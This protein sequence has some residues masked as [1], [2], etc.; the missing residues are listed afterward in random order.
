M[1]ERRPRLILAYVVVGLG[2]MALM[3]AITH[4]K[5]ALIFGAMF[6]Y[7]AAMVHGLTF[8]LRA[9][10]RAE[11]AVLLGASRWILGATLV[12][13]AGTALANFILVA[14]YVGSDRA[15]TSADAT[16]ALAWAV[17]VMV[18]CYRVWV[19][20]SARRAGF[21][22]VIAVAFAVPGMLVTIAR[23]TRPFYDG[24]RGLVHHVPHDARIVLGTAMFVTFIV[25]AA[26]GPVLDK[27]F[28]SIDDREVN[29][30]PAAVL[31]A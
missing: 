6:G 4:H 31:R 27:L 15:S 5:S 12:A 14:V 8:A 10:S 7:L 26:A 2:I 22:Q 11:P 29:V 18:L 25:V 17:A 19:R 24:E 16:P 21:L 3:G 20:P 9:R 23:V 30:P 13:V 1:S 28:A